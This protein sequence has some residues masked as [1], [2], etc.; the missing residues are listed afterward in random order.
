MDGEPDSERRECRVV[1]ISMLGLG[2]VFQHP[3]PS[4]LVGGRISVE[5]SAVDD[6][7]NIRLEGVVRYATATSGG[8]VRVGVEFD[9]E[10]AES[11]T[12]TTDN[13][14]TRP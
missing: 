7:V 6:R 12:I 8:A 1:D 11:Y 5:V 9:D 14:K 10:E 13:T 3:S 2:L 4:A